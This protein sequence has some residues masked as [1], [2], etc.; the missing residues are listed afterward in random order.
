MENELIKYISRF[1]SLNEEEKKALIEN[2][3]ILT[4][5]KGTILLREGEV[6]TRCWFVIKGCV[7]QYFLKDGDEKTTAFYTEEQTIVPS[8]ANEQ[9]TPSKYYLSCVEESR[10]VVT[11]LDRIPEMY[12]KFPKFESISLILAGKM[13]EDSSESFAS[14]RTSSPEERY[15]NLLKTRPELLQRVPQHQIASYLGIT[16]ES[17]SRIRKRISL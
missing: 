10:L 14:F 12:E 16:P 11:Y 17:L 6:A 5:K 15:R 8:S 3:P 13:Y 4:F 7:R 2:N 1:I 9:Q